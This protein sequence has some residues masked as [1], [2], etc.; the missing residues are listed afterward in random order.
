MGERHSYFSFRLFRESGSQH[1]GAE[2]D[3][4]YSVMSAVVPVED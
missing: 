2:W 4:L 3:E 1:D